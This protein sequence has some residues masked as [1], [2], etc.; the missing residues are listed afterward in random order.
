MS[1]EEG[2]QRRPGTG[3]GRHVPLSCPAPAA[4]GPAPWHA[5]ASVGVQ[6]GTMEGMHA[7]PQYLEQPWLKAAPPEIRSSDFAQKRGGRAT[8]NPVDRSTT[9]LY[10]W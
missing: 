6:A 9:K 8:A 10:H 2:V 5:E 7:G 3:W 4:L 1:Q